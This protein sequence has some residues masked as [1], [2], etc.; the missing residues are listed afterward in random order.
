M[1]KIYETLR[2]KNDST[3][4]VY[5]NIESQNIPN[6]AVTETKLGTNAVTTGKLANNSVNSNKLAD[7]SV[8]TTKLVDYSVTNNK[9]ADNSIS[10]AKMQIDSVNTSNIVNGAI[11]TNKIQNNAVTT[12]KIVSNSI[13][14]IH[15]NDYLFNAIT[16]LFYSYIITFNKSGTFSGIMIGTITFDEILRE[17]S[18]AEIENALKFNKASSSDYS[19]ADISI[20]TSFL[21]CLSTNFNSTAKGKWFN[22]ETYDIFIQL[23][24]ETLYRIRIR[25]NGTTIYEIQWNP[26]TNTITSF[27]NTDLNTYISLYSLLNNDATYER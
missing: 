12:G 22:N 5:P 19:S 4:E 11:T 24:S 18:D 15:L 20:L 27:T 9:I 2:K 6:G 13:T 8:S 1:A 25:N 17:Y 10:N 26:Q 23:Y 21:E 16:R 7:G 3:I 14:S